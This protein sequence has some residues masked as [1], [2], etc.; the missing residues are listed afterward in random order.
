MPYTVTKRTGDGRPLPSFLAIERD[1]GKEVEVI[2]CKF[3]AIYVLV[4]PSVGRQVTLVREIDVRPDGIRDTTA[5]NFLG[6]KLP[7]GVKH[8][9]FSVGRERLLGEIQS[10]GAFDLRYVKKP[11]ED[12]QRP[13]KTEEEKPVDAAEVSKV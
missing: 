3:G 8:V 4:P 10:Q 6:M 1:T 9:I 7:Y 11:E 12:R 2:R 5:K 13:T